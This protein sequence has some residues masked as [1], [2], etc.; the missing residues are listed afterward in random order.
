M[1]FQRSTVS[2]LE[3]EKL[4]SQSTSFSSHFATMRHQPWPL[5]TS[6]NWYNFGRSVRPEDFVSWPFYRPKGQ[7]WRNEDP[8]PFNTKIA[9][10][11]WVC[12]VRQFQLH[13]EKTSDWSF[14]STCNNPV[15]GNMQGWMKQ[16]VRCNFNWHFAISRVTRQFPC[17]QKD[18]ALAIQDSS[19]LFHFPKSIWF[20][21][22]LQAIIVIMGIIFF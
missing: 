13:W 18:N 7:R 15:V 19:L 20:C 2:L 21:K 16:W 1:V 11:N 17:F 3:F 14:R 8:L 22:S 12:D 4:R 6:I 5:S 9:L 10:Q